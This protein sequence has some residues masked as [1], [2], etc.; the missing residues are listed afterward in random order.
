MQYKIIFV[1]WKCLDYSAT[2]ILIPVF[3]KLYIYKYILYTLIYAIKSILTSNS[4]NIVRQFQTIVIKKI[5][6]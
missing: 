6:V 5:S 1:L 3:D 4:I 2:F